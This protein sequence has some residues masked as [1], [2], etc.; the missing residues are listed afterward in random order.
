MYR[1]MYGNA[2]TQLPTGVFAGMTA[3]Q[4]LYERHDVRNAPESNQDR[5]IPNNVITF[6]S[7]YAFSGLTALNTLWVCYQLHSCI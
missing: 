4:F 2:V 1:D 5:E 6:V 7:Q 3:L